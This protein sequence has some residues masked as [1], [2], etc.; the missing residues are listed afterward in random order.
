MTFALISHCVTAFSIENIS[1]KNIYKVLKMYTKCWKHENDVFKIMKTF[2]NIFMK[3]VQQNLTKHIFMIIFH[4]HWKWKQ[5][6]GKPNSPLFCFHL[7]FCIVLMISYHYRKG[8]DVGD[9]KPMADWC[10]H[11]RATGINQMGRTLVGLAQAGKMTLQPM[12]WWRR[13]GSTECKDSYPQLN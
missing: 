1:N 6:I 8:Y 4:F 11:I 12:I 13:Q 5:E 3:Y 10:R 2:E 7:Q 9:K